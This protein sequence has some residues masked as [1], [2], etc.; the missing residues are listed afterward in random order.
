MNLK[1]FKPKQALNKAYLK[2]P[3]HQTNFDSFKNAL[4]Q[5]KKSSENGVLKGENENTLKSH[6]RDFLKSSF[7][8]QNYINP[9]KLKGNIE[10]DFAI[11]KENNPS[12][13]LN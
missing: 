11:H 7:Y 3:I 13:T 9:Y 10:A 1:I 2:L 8:E 5:Y 12:S 6:I 4:E